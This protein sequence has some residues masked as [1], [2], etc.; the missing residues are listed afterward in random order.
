MDFSRFFFCFQLYFAWIDGAANSTLSSYTVS[1]S[2]QD[3]VL[4]CRFR[5]G[6]STSL[7]TRGWNG[8]STCSSTYYLFS[9]V[10]LP[11]QQQ[12]WVLRFVL[13]SCALGFITCIWLVDIPVSSLLSLNNSKSAAAFS[14]PSSRRV[15]PRFHLVPK[16][17]LQ[18]P[19]ISG[20]NLSCIRFG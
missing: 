16:H 17:F 6:C 15:A 19:P 11:T 9:C 14:S 4:D 5:D 12:K 7:G 2:P 1:G 18:S 3:F 8:E 10:R 20:M 13:G